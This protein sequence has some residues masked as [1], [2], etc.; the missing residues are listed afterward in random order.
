MTKVDVGTVIK[1]S[2]FSLAAY[3][4]VLRL[5]GGD[6]SKFEKEVGAKFKKSVKGSRAPDTEKV[7]IN[8]I[9]LVCQCKN[10][11]DVAYN[12]P[13]GFGCPG[14]MGLL[15]LHSSNAL[16]WVKMQLASS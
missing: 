6:T 8:R 9:I 7:S 15:D 2:V 14:T 12:N 16:S 1:N 13:D 4:E 11:V 3:W 10:G 5:K